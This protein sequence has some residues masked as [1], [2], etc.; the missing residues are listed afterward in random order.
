MALLRRRTPSIPPEK[1]VPET[2]TPEPARPSILDAYVHDTPSAQTAVD[3]FAGE[4]TS[5]LPPDAGATAGTMPLWADPRIEWILDRAGGAAGK[6]VIEL[7]PLEAGHTY[8]LERAGADVT[9]IEGNS[10][11]YLKC[12]IVKELVGLPNAHF[13][14]GDFLPYLETSERRVD[15]L[16]ASGVLYH[17]PDP[18]RL[19]TAMARVSDSIGIWTHYFDPSMFEHNPGFGKVF[20]APHGQ[21]WG[22]SAGERHLRLHRRL[23]LDALEFQGFCGG[24]AESAVWMELDDITAVLTDLGFAHIEIGSNDLEHVHGPCVLLYAS[25]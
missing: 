15:L 6:S 12:L 25:R 22:S 21:V 9:A 16:V 24:A 23:Y 4:W 10:R 2:T 1:G 20:A 18:V 11:A 13:E 3:V 17:A 7:G 5:A 19:L 14:L 8:M